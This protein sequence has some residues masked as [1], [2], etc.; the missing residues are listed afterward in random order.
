MQEV[1]LVVGR[2]QLTRACDQ[3]TQ[4]LLLHLP[5][6]GELPNAELVRARTFF[7]M[8]FAPDRLAYTIADFLDDC[9]EAPEVDAEVGPSDL[10][11]AG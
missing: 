5:P 6:A 4:V 7:E 1:D 10:A 11:E 8:R 3:G 2:Q 9:W